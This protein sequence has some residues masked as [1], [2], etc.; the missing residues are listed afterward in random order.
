MKRRVLL[1][2]DDAAL[3]RLIRDEL[4]AEGYLVGE[5]TSVAIARQQL[6]EKVFDLVVTDL[7][8]PD[9]TGHDVLEAARQSEPRPACL[10]ITAFGSVSDAVAALKKGADDFLTKPLEMDHFL[11]SVDRLI[12]QS[13]LRRDYARLKEVIQSRD[14]HGIT[15]NSAQIQRLREQITVIAATDGP[16]L[17]TGESGTGK[18]L[19]ARS[20]HV[21]SGRRDGPFVAINCAGIPGELIESEL[22][23]HEAG[24][25]TD[26]KKKHAG[27]FRQASGGTLLLDE[28][29]E[30]PLTL[31]AK[32]LRVL[33]E[34]SVRSIG[35][36]G[37]QAVD[38]RVVAATH[39]NV[40]AL[41]ASGAF[42]EDLYYRLETFKLEVP[43]LRARHG[44]VEL[45]AYLFL[46]QHASATGRDI[47]GFDPAALD[48][49]NAYA[50]PGNVRELSNIIER[51]VAFCQGTL[52]SVGDLPGRIL[53][54][55][56]ESST[57]QDSD[58][59]EDGKETLF[60][61]LPTLDVLQRRYARQVLER[62]D[63]NKQQA[64]AI[65][66]VTRSTLY[67]WLAQE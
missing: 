10:V 24:A 20:L 59:R 21:Q 31:Q 16:V 1:V 12:E 64:A 62:T 29:G 35:A 34:G 33:Q 65:L 13:F 6:A 67:R 9:G 5:A 25:F 63:G 38:V 14:N 32:L 46:R 28:I 39:R 56:G 23:G 55:Q 40:E 2:E 11:L 4:D 36:S 54:S 7:R 37:E 18:E 43:P 47:D 66:G 61:D 30:M 49:L 26:A 57:G 27:I 53:E 3:L 51:A 8:L 17:V 52:I 19:V 41:V 60:D 22:F 48:T 44:D 45:L 50:F 42:R 58:T 15:G